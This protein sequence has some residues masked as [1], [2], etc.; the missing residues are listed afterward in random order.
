MSAKTTGRSPPLDEPEHRR[1]L[2]RTGLL[3][4]RQLQDNPEIDPDSVD[5]EIYRVRCYFDHSSA[6]TPP[7]K[8]VEPEADGEIKVVLP[9]IATQD[10]VCPPEGRPKVTVITFNVTHNHLARA[11]VLADLLRN[12]YQVELVGTVFPGFGN[13]IWKPLQQSRV[14][15]KWFYG[16]NLPIYFEQL[17][18]VA[19]KIDGDII[20]VSKPT[21]PSYMLGIILKSLRNRP[22]ILDI[23]DF[24]I[25]SFTAP[26]KLDQVQGANRDKDFYEPYGR[27]WRRYCDSIV[28]YADAVTVTNVALQTR[29]GGVIIPQIRDESAYD[30]TLYDRDAIRAEFGYEK[31]DR[32]ILFLGTP[33]WHKGVHR[34]AEALQKLGNKRYKLCIIGSILDDELRQHL[35]NFRNPSFL[36]LP[37]QPFH[38]A[39]KNLCLAD[40]VCLL[41]DPTNGKASY[42]MPAK[43]ADALAMGVPVLG[44]QTPP[45]MRAAEDGL[46]EALGDKPLHEKIDEIFRNYAIHKQR[47]IRNRVKFF[48][49]YSYA[50]NRS[51]LID[52]IEGFY[53]A[54]PAVPR[55][56]S[57]LIA[58]H[59]ELRELNAMT[60][61]EF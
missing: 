39:P 46:I 50:A 12:H 45:L 59:D 56:F 37:D 5:A 47:A 24:E 8:L 25:G 31:D 18:K 23:D 51:K 32:V 2:R 16:M 22:L 44:T 14:P 20:V 53:D 58:F 60:D 9:T 42:Q 61:C 15:I 33:Y 11:Y 19:N 7:D 57:R 10:A 48:E 34:V 21:F 55:E 28:E 30:P 52:V 4:L 43:F 49:Q 13:G 38:D 1:S 17:K 35:F 6:N 54:P 26:L 41:Q 3:R 40:L 29:Y 36:F 27:L